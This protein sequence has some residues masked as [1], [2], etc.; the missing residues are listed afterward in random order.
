M[1][2]ES[3]GA[4][5]NTQTKPDVAMQALMPVAQNC[6]QRIA[7]GIVKRVHEFPARERS[8][9]QLSDRTLDSV[10]GQILWDALQ[11]EAAPVFV[12]YKLIHEAF[13]TSPTF[14][15]RAITEFMRA[16]RAR[17]GVRIQ[18]RG[19]VVAPRAFTPTRSFRRPRQV[20]SGSPR[21]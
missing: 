19:A 7:E 14:F 11:A 5:S 10:P 17:F 1:M 18:P 20:R 16:Q 3:L 15:R 4:A 12:V 13:S 8:L 21:C 9:A 6:G 2:G